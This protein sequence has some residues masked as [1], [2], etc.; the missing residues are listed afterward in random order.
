MHGADRRRPHSGELADSRWDCRILVAE[1]GD[2][3]LQGRAAKHIALAFPSPEVVLPH[4]RP[5]TRLTLWE[6]RTIG[7]GIVVGI[8]L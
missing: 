4:L 2:P 6:T 1:H 8:E 7:T 5:G 3:I